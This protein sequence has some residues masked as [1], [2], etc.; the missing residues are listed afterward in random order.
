[1]EVP[2]EDCQGAFFL[3]GAVGEDGRYE[4]G[5]RR[6]RWF[7]MRV[8]VLVC[9]PPWWS[10]QRGHVLRALCVAW[11][12]ILATSRSFGEWL[13]VMRWRRSAACLV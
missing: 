12:L 6:C 10:T 4:K 5:S 8:L 1:M 3:A 13:W 11:S 7:Q 2:A 9:M